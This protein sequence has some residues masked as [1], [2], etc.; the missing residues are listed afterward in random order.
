MGCRRKLEQWRVKKNGIVMPESHQQWVDGVGGT[1]AVVAPLLLMF[2]FFLKVFFLIFILYWSI[3]DLQCCVSFR[4]TPKWSVTH[5]TY[6]VLV[7]ADV[8]KHSHCRCG[9]MSLS[10]TTPVVSEPSNAR[11]E[12]PCLCFYLFA[13]AVFWGNHGTTHLKEKDVTNTWDQKTRCC[14]VSFVLASRT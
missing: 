11:N 13:V 4:R 7:H 5:N 10:L 14:L 12:P 1:V 3:V 2:L 9:R 6:I 8:F